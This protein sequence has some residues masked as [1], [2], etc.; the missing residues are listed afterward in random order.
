MSKTKT[1]IHWG[2]ILIFFL[3][4]SIL[5][6]LGVGYMGLAE[7]DETSYP[8]ASSYFYVNDYSGV[9][10]TETEQFLRD[11]AIALE[12]ATEAQIVVVA[13]PDTGAESLETYSY[14]L[15]SSWGIG[16]EEK[17]NGLLLL[18]TTEEA[19]VRLEV[20]RG[21]EGEIP[22]GKAGRILDEYTVVPMR[23]GAWNEAAVQT[24]LALAQ[25]LYE[26]AGLPLPEHFASVSVVEDSWGTTP[27][28]ASL[29]LTQ[30]V[31]SSSQEEVSWFLQIAINFVVFWVF[32]FLPFV[33]LSFLFFVRGKGSTTY[34]GTS[35][36]NNHG[37]GFGG[38]GGGSD[39]GGFGG[40]G[41]GFGGGGA[42]R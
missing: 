17:D 40:G 34:Y 19:H 5:G 30:P 33:F 31:D 14:G 6:T 39:F 23:G 27:A 42:S 7:A 21:L 8:Q 37:G 4:S 24:W 11:G 1:R 12:Q 32:F 26:E 16:N 22:D 18:F 20:G 3:L 10:S 25:I 41:G 36:W 2:G 15:A 9:F 13:V 29:S 38:F 28:D 35:H